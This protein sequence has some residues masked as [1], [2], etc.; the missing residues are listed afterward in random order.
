MDCVYGTI[1]PDVKYRAFRQSGLG[2]WQGTIQMRG[3]ILWIYWKWM[4]HGVAGAVAGLHEIWVQFR[5]AFSVDLRVPKSS[6]QI[7]CQL[8]D[9]T[10]PRHW[11]STCPRRI[12]NRYVELES[13]CRVDVHLPTWNF[14]EKG[15]NMP[16]V[17]L[18]LIAI[19]D[20]DTC[21]KINH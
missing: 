6:N 8:H 1:A 14:S 19:N 7:K 16:L 17:I 15:S 2:L 4:D 3:N 12:W 21:T 5:I 9:L 11:C 20:I 13:T 18:S 10:C